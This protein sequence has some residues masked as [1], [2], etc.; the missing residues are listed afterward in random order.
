MDDQTTSVDETAEEGA[1]RVPEGATVDDGAERAGSEAEAPA[2]HAEDAG[3]DDAES[4]DTESIES[5]IVDETDEQVADEAEDGDDESA[6]SASDG[7]DWYV[8][9]K[10]L[11]NG[12]Q[13]VGARA[14]RGMAA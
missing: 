7:M 11:Q 5:V 13:S 12:Q 9:R 8:S 1:P 2:A 3:V 14:S 4:D 10:V 6:E